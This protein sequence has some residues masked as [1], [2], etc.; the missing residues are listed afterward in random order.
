M[1]IGAADTLRGG[2]EDRTIGRTLRI[3]HVPDNQRFANSFHYGSFHCVLLGTSP[4]VRST[5]RIA[6]R[7]AAGKLFRA[8]PAAITPPACSQVRCVDLHAVQAGLEARE[9]DLAA[10]LLLF[11][12]H[13]PTIEEIPAVRRRARKSA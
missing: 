13:Q 10:G 5:F 9:A 1:P 3:G 11:L 12:A 2:L 8:S 6:P 4:C 7:P